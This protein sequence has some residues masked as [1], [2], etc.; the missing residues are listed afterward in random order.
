MGKLDFEIYPIM[1]K[2]A[3]ELCSRLLTCAE[4]CLCIAGYG[5]GSI[6]RVLG[7]FEPI[8]TVKMQIYVLGTSSQIFKA[9]QRLKNRNKESVTG[10]F[11]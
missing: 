6:S 7:I 8:P 5:K 9:I 2:N 4:K 3:V 1:Q 11:E 10:V